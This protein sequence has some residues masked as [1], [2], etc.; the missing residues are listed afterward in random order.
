MFMKTSG[1]SGSP[2][3]LMAGLQSLNVNGNITQPDTSE[4]SCSKTND[5]KVYV[6]YK[7][8]EMEQKINQKLDDL[9][10]SQN[11]KLDRIL[12]LLGRSAIKDSEA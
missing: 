3:G 9:E 12:E 11:E 6:D 2:L 10:K 7:F 5:L 1:T 8:K 4:A